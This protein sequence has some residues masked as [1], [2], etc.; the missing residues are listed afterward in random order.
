MKDLMEL[1]VSMIDNRSFHIG[2]PAGQAADTEKVKKG[3][4]EK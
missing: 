1:A 4:T 3:S 2:M